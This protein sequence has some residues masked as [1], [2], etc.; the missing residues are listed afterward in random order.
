MHLSKG[1]LSAHIVFD[2]ADEVVHCLAQTFDECGSH[3]MLPQ[4]VHDGQHELTVVDF[5]LHSQ[6]HESMAM[7]GVDDTQIIVVMPVQLS[8]DVQ[9]RLS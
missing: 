5:V 4:E 3:A 2:A 6:S 8:N 1:V 9:G 7:D